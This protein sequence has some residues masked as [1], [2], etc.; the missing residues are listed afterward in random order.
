MTQDLTIVIDQ[1]TIAFFVLLGFIV[2][3]FFRRGSQ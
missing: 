3:I 1:N 2:W